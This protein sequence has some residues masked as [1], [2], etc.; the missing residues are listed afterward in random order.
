MVAG[1]R[2]AVRVQ[3]G[4]RGEGVLG[5]FEGVLRIQVTAPPKEGKANRAVIDL[6]ARTIG[7]K[8]S[9]ITL[10]RGHRSRDKVLKVDG[11]SQEEA[12]RLLAAV[13]GVS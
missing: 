11:L 8:R 4:A 13:G 6:V 12:E 7:V 9:Q 5:Y 2:I 3:P 10:L 1:A